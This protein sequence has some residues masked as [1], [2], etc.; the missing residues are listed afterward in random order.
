MLGFYDDNP[1]LLGAEPI[2]GV[3]VLGDTKELPGGLETGNGVV[4]LA[5]GENRVRCGLSR[6]MSVPYGVA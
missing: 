6:R 5:V 4:I 1:A 3:K 2:P